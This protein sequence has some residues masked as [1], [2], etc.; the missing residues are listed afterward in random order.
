VNVTKFSELVI[1]CTKKS[2]TIETL[3]V[4]FS[5][6]TRNRR[7]SLYHTHFRHVA[8]ILGPA[9]LVVATNAVQQ[10]KA[11]FVQTLFYFYL[12]LLSTHPIQKELGSV[13]TIKGRQ[14]IYHQLYFY[15]TQFF[16]SVHCI[17]FTSSSC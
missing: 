13:G 2:G 9:I 6:P 4:W 15:N 17:G 14:C 1:E 8:N 5:L 11:W 3:T 16:W 7:R 12:N 10:M